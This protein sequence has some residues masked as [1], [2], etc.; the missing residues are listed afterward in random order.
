M[1]EVMADVLPEAYLQIVQVIDSLIIRATAL[2]PSLL[3][4]CL[5]TVEMVGPSAVF[6]TLLGIPLGVILVITGS[7]HIMPSPSV[8]RT[9]GAVI[10]AT[11]SVPFNILAVAIIPFTRFLVG[12]A[13][14]PKGMIVPLTLATTPFIARLIET[15][16]I[17]V[18]RGLIEAAQAMGAS[19]RQVIFKVLLPEALPGIVS[20]LTVSL[21]MLISFSSI[22]GMF[23]GGGLGD[24]AIRYGYQ[25]YMPEVMW[26]IVVILIVLVQII[27]VSGDKI[28]AKVNKR[29]IKRDT[30]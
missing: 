9:L 3:N 30:K 11:R 2:G 19:P 7:G 26:T 12:T 6:A 10:N 22:A 27:Q 4:A 21:I 13:I 25:R 24:M 5:Q 17:E 16:L 8:N 29:K 23:G 15:A 14:E 18:D 20:G 28:A 1:S